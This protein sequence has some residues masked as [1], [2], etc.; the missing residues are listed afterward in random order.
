MKVSDFTVLE[1]AGGKVAD[2]IDR[3]IQDA[4]EDVADVSKP[5]E[6]IRKVKLEIQLVPNEERTRFVYR[7]RCSTA[8]PGVKPVLGDAYI[9]R[10]GGSVRASEVDPEQLP[11]T[12]GRTTD[13]KPLEA[14]SSFPA[15]G[16][17]GGDS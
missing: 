10:R 8:V 9:E 1:M 15:N 3:A 14:V 2:I 11:L 5:A 16:T 7:V 4:L 17:T 6:E 12:E 13:G